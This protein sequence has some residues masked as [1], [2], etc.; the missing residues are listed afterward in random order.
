MTIQTASI[1]TA[2]QRRTT[3]FL[4]AAA[5]AALALGAVT[6]IGAWQA[7]RDGGTRTTEQHVA[8]APTPVQRVVG[9]AIDTAPTY[10]LVGSAAQAQAAGAALEEANAVR[11]TAGEP[12]LAGQVETLQSAEAEARLLEAIADADT[13][14][15]G[16]GI[17]PVR[18]IDLRPAG[19]PAVGATAR[20]GAVGEGVAPRGGMAELYAE[21]QA[22]VAATDPAPTLG[23]LAE[24]Y[25]ERETEVRA[26]G[27]RLERMGG[28]AELYRDQAASASSAV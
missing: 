20:S 15:Y 6:G 7:S 1:V 22:P 25:A 3:R 12:S 5:G 11:A 14:R 19:E 8:S 24:L 2:P 13:I 26:D 17:P 27:A 21:Q 18:V 16:L 28:M 23:G 10:Y 9:R 4:T